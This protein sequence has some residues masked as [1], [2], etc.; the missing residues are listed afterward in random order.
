M[1]GICAIEAHELAMLSEVG[2]AALERHVFIR[3]GRQTSSRACNYP[4]LFSASSRRRRLTPKVVVGRNAHDISQMPKALNA[5][6]SACIAS[7]ER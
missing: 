1:L 7:I 5:H 6:N 2:A 3:G 4:L